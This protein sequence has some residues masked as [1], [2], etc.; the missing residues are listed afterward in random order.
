GPNGTD[1]GA[2]RRAEMSV[3]VLARGPAGVSLSGVPVGATPVNSATI[4]VGIHR[5]GSGIPTAGF[6]EGSGY[7]HYRWRLDGGAWSAETPSTTP[8]SLTGLAQGPHAVEVTGRR[9]SGFY[10]DDPVF[11]EDAVRT[12]SRT[13][14]VKASASPVRLNEVLAR[15]V[16]AV[17]V[18]GGHPDL[19]ELYNS[20]NAPV[21]LAGWGLTDEPDVPFKFTF[22]ANASIDPGQYL[23]LYA[24]SETAPAGF[25]LGFSLQAQGDELVLTMPNGLQ[26]DAVTF[27]MQVADLSIARTADGEWVLSRPTL[28]AANRAARLGDP[29]SL[30]I[31]EW[32]ADGIS[33]YADD[34]IEL[35]NPDPLPVA[36]GG[37]WIT[38]SASGMRDRHQLAPL[39]FIAGGGFVVLIADGRPENGADHLNFSLAA[40]QGNIGLFK[41]DLTLIDCVVYG[42]QRTDASQGRQPNGAVTYGFFT[43]PTPGSPNP[44][45]VLP[46]TTVVINEILADNVTRAEVDGTTPDWI[47]LFNPTAAPINLADMSL[48]DNATEPRRFVFPSVTIPSLGYLVVRME[49][50]EPVSATNSGFGL[51]AGGGAVYLFDRLANG[52]SLLSSVTYGV[53]ARDFSIGRVPDGSDN[54]VLTLP[55][56]RA[57]NIAQP[58]G[59]PLTL[60]VNEWMAAPGTGSE[61]WF[62]I[63]NP[64]GLPVA[65]A[66]LHLTDNLGNRTKFKIAPLSFI[67]TGLFGFQRFEADD[68]TMAGPDH[69]NFALSAGGES[70][71]I[72]NT[73]GALIDSYTFGQQVTGASQGRLPDG[74]TNV[75]RF[76]RTVSP[77]ES[78]YLPLTNVVINEVLTHTDPPFEDAIELR[79]LTGAPVDISGWWLSDSKDVLKKFRIP[80]G[81]VIPANGFRVYYEYQFNHETNLAPFSLNSAK[82]DQVYLSAST[83]AGVLTGYRDVVEFGAAAN[84]VSFGRHV[85]S[86]GVDFTA[87]SAHTFGADNATTT[88]EFR[89]GTGLPNAYPLVGPV[90]ISEIMY[91]PTNLTAEVEAEEYLELLNISANTALLYHPAFPTNTWRLRDA[92]KFDFPPN[93]AIPAGGSVLVVNFDPADTAALN[94]FRARYHL[95]AGVPVY[96]PFEGRLDNGSDSIELYAPDAPQAPPDPDAGYVPYILVDKVRYS[97]TA[98]WPSCGPNCGADGGGWSLQRINVDEYGNDP[99][100]W[101]A[102]VPSPGPAGSGDSDGDGMPDAWEIAHGLNPAVNDANGDLDLDGLTNF[103]EY[104]A[105]TAPNDETSSL[106]LVILGTGPAQLRFQAAA[107]KAYVIE[108]KDDL[109]QTAWTLLSNVPAGVARPVTINDATVRATRFYRVR[110]Q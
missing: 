59:N 86:V 83:V 45:V 94:A 79:N 65:L 20:G 38:D 62:E 50:S 14:L 92:V 98:P 40:E 56:R 110:L 67:G 8:L 85:T 87:Q 34:F 99:V 104:L 24:D 61:D 43:T 10:Q 96:G 28:G 22:P 6:P 39:S 32:L 3:G 69:V 93:V 29:A 46:G 33:P 52:G 58:L 71:A 68:N 90:V 72:A 30:R 5:T 73:N 9:D 41:G 25:H 12:V 76:T 54:W 55:S 91:H 60:K 107:D 89:L 100:N 77:E 1:L 101:M 66:G 13:W 31:N 95:A 2:G 63:Y 106:R 70:L 49:G 23:V 75:V 17:P 82:G 21:N 16:S 42:P 74:S 37:L 103:E 47:E 48:S 81:T 7:T 109:A 53:Q 64:D 15:N 88:N 4:T 35:F 19:V 18:A 27:G 80:N 97:D 108:Y 11:E 26:A 44:A 51:K 57:P 102:A 84:G 36:L 78:N 105:G